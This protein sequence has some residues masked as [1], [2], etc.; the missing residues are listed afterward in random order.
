MA[1]VRRRYT[2]VGIDPGTTIGVAMLDLDGRPI[3]IF[4]AKNYSVSDVVARIIS[5]GKPLIVASDV[6][7]TP[8]MVKRI[9]SIFATLVPELDESLSLEDKI[10][11]TKGAGYEYKNAHERDALAASVTAFKHYSKKFS[12]VQKKTPAGVNVEEVK[13]Q[14]IK[15]VSISAAIDRLISLK[16]EN[17]EFIKE[18]RKEEKKSNEENEENSRLRRIIKGKDEKIAMLEELT[19]ALKAIDA[20]KE[21]KISRLNHKLDSI[22]SEGRRKMAVIEEIRRRDNKIA[23]LREELKEK[24]ELN[25]ELRI[26]IEELKGKRGVKGGK[27]IKLI[28][29]FSH[30]AI[31]DAHRRYGL[32]KGDVVFLEDG[33]GGGASTAELLAKK[34]ISAVIYGKEL[35][36][37][38]TNTFLL[39]HIP[40]FSIDEIPLLLKEE[41]GDF[42]FVDQHLLNEKMKE[43]KAGKRKKKVILFR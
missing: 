32:K 33:S 11:L 12:Q 1:H 35:S 7:P 41:N 13:A 10:A 39:F 29:S 26:I 31:L 42:V 28:K 22:R 25:A 16:R 9:S 18:E 17:K 36:H 8:S 40:S 4:S 5:L 20:E 14:V 43:W 2:I 19:T 27:R 37:F 38:A 23:R 21:L 15:G 3:D 30:D 24:D 6:T 34:G